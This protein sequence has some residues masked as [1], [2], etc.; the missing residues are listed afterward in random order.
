MARTLGAKSARCFVE[1]AKS[2][3][4]LWAS[5]AGILPAEAAW[6]V[7]HQSLD[8][9]ENLV[10]A[11]TRLDVRGGEVGAVKPGQRLGA[12]VAELPA[13]PLDKVVVLGRR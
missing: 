12:G 2:S 1:G 8:L 5:F 13:A 3:A 7:I 9:A 4:V 11:Q 10:L 6:R